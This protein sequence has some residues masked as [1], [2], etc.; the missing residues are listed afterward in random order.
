MA[1]WGNQL[2]FGKLTMADADMTLI[3]MNPEDPF[4]FDLDHYKDQLVPGYSKFTATFGL[5]VYMKD[6]A[7]VHPAAPAKTETKK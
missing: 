5:R 1:Y 6:F 4:D 3:D 7:K 2:R